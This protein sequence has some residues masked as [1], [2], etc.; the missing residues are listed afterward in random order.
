MFFNCV[1]WRDGGVNPVATST[2]LQAH[3]EKIAVGSIT[4]L[5]HMCYQPSTRGRK[6]RGAGG[7]DGP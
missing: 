6:P 7:S 4:S 1:L 2:K 3:V 5:N